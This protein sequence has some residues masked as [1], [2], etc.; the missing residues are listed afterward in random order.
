MNNNQ[1]FL[2]DES[3]NKNKINET[4][5]INDKLIHATQIILGCHNYNLE[6]YNLFSLYVIYYVKCQNNLGCHN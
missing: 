1:N 6:C 3:D 2:N 4:S 5:N